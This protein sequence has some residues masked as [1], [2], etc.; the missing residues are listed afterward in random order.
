[1]AVG[2]PK[3]KLSTAMPTQIVAYE[4][5]N[6][7]V[8][9]AIIIGTLAAITATRRPNLSQIRKPASSPNGL[10]M[11]ARAAVGI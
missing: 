5:V 8:I 9:N 11:S 7:S 4:S 1:M 3:T 2:N 10:Q 6:P